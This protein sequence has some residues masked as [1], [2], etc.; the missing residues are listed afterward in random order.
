MTGR[1]VDYS[2]C[3]SS[4]GDHALPRRRTLM[5]FH[6][7]PAPPPLLPPALIVAAAGL[8]VGDTELTWR[9]SPMPTATVA[10]RVRRVCIGGDCGR[11]MDD[12]CSGLARRVF[13]DIGG[14]NTLVM[15]SPE[16][17]S[18][19]VAVLMDGRDDVDVRVGIE[20]NIVG[21][22]MWLT[23]GG[24]GVKQAGATEAN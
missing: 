16:P 4:D 21:C 10:E 24:G 9:P 22:V 15:P 14:I 2:A 19:K 13:G 17:G 18:A 11:G 20:E 1:G 5:R 6:Q 12:V 7:A 23:G 3:D 8:F